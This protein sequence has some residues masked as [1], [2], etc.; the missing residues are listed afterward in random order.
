MKAKHLGSTKAIMWP[1]SAAVCHCALGR[2]ESLGGGQT[3][4]WGW[5]EG[6]SMEGIPR[7]GSVGDEQMS[8]GAQDMRTV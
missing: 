5:A 7:R 8:L 6:R 2:G 3:L 4:Q 1:Y